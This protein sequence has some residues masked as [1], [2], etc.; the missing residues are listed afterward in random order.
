MP[1]IRAV[2]TLRPIRQKK[3]WSY[4]P[5]QGL[6]VEVP[7]ECVGENLNGIAQ[8]LIA[9]RIAFSVETSGAVSRLILSASGGQAGI[10][11]LAVDEWQVTGNEI[12]NSLFEHWAVSG[13]TDAVV[14]T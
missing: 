9:N 6:K 4:D 1:K 5:N 10:P 8:Q 2:G 11:N 14:D 12:Q 7:Y 3:K 13:L